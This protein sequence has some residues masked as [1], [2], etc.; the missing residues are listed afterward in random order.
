MKDP[1][2][3]GRFGCFLPF[4]LTLTAVCGALLFAWKS[5]LWRRVAGEIY[6]LEFTLTVERYA[7]E[8]GLPRALVY[9]VIRTESGFDP[10]AVSRA[11]AKGLMQLTDATNEWVA[12]YLLGEEAQNERIFEPDVNIRRGT[13]LLAYLMKEFGGET[14]TAV[15][16][17][18][19]GIGRVKGWLEDERYSSDGRTLHTIPIAETR[20]YVSRVRRAAEK[21]AELLSPDAAS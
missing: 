1:R 6:P 18:N 15:A 17:Y 14:D 4:F 8:N 7:D 20:N 2:K 11:D 3:T 5:G 9:A 13:R 12:V 16:A 10:N 19:A 21:Y